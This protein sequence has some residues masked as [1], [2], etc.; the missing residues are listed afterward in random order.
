MH[1]DDKT[2]KQPLDIVLPPN[3]HGTDADVQASV[4]LQ[5]KLR[6]DISAVASMIN[7]IEWLRKQLEDQRKAAAPPALDAMDKK[8]QDVEFQL[9]SRSDALSDDKDTEAARLYLNF[10]WLNLSLGSGTGKYAGGAD[11]APT[12]TSLTMA[13]DLEAELHAVQA[14]FKKLMDV[15]VPEYNR[16]APGLGLAPLGDKHGK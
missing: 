4:R 5:L 14:K 13:H 3:S 1:F 15:D 6:D 10:L 12:E 16:A 9:I 2:Y 7:Q 11:Y 8:L